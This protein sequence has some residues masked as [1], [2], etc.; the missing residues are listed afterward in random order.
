MVI[1]NSGKHIRSVLHCLKQHKMCCLFYIRNNLSLECSSKISV[2]ES[3][4]VGYLDIHMVL[5]LEEDTV[6][7]KII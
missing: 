5:N 4:N 1:K 6:Q 7:K 3:S 2:E